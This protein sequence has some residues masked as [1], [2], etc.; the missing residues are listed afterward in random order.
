[1][2][3]GTI[4]ADQIIYQHTIPAQLR[5]VGPSGG[6]PPYFYQ[7]ES[8]DDNVNFFNISGATS[9]NYQPEQL[10]VTTYFRQIQI[11]TPD[12]SVATNVVTITVTPLPPPTQMITNVIVGNNQTQCYDASQ[13]MTVAGDGTTFLVQSGGAVNLIAGQKIYLLAGSKVEQSGCLHG[14]ITISGQYCNNLTIPI[15]ANP[16]ELAEEATGTPENFSDNAFGCYP[17]PNTGKFNLW[18]SKEPGDT[19]VLVR[20]YNLLGV[21]IFTRT[22]YAGK[23]HEF[24][25]ENQVAGIY[26]VSV[27]QNGKVAIVK[28]VRQ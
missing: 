19:P 9:I 16:V 10:D 11:S 24:S 27:M 15:P 8:S 17:N 12:F 26:L 4:A 13:I 5:G 1:M 7:W 21:D 28:V 2:V 23:F 3:A 14:F 22:I 25:L 18:L 20:I 6:N